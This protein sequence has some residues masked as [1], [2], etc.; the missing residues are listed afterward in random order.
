MEKQGQTLDSAQPT[1]LVRRGR[2]M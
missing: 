2:Y 1:V